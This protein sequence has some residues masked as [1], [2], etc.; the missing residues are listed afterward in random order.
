MRNI[1]KYWKLQKR[2]FEKVSDVLLEFLVLG[3]GVW[4]RGSKLHFAN[5][6]HLRCFGFTVREFV[7]CLSWNTVSLK[8]N[9]QTC[10]NSAVTSQSQ[11]HFLDVTRLVEVKGYLFT[12]WVCFQ[13]PPLE[14]K[15]ESWAQSLL[16]ES[17]RGLEMTDLWMSMKRGR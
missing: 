12:A 5:R 16:E 1:E 3:G 17:S 4:V 9:D 10:N 13:T 11:Q 6:G 14:L 15:N 8:I 7:G 2:S